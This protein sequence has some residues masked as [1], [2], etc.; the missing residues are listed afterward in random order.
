VT[1]NTAAARDSTRCSSSGC[2]K[3][4]SVLTTL[5]R[6]AV[7][8]SVYGRACATRSWA[9][10]SREAEMSSMALVI[11]MVDRTAPMRRRTTRSCAGMGF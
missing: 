7:I 5:S 8:S 6:A 9:L 3:S 10:T 11:F 4:T 2:V 1:T